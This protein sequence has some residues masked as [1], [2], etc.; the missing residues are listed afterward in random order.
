ML[1]KFTVDAPFFSVGSG[2]VGLTAEQARARAH[3]L[4]AVKVGKDGAGEY[5]VRN[6]IQFKRGES[7]G[8]SGEVGKNGQL[9]DRD[10]EELRRMEQAETVEK[11]VAA[12]RSAALKQAR[13][14]Y[15]A[16]LTELRTEI[17]KLRDELAA[18]AKK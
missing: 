17:Q 14:E 11:A 16:K 1:K 8:Y 15:E 6:M 12:A 13:E 5:E 3:N 4:K 9:T 10:A 18:A 7:F 2:I